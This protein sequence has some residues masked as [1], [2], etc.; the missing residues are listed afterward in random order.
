MQTAMDRVIECAYAACVGAQ[1][2]RLEPDT[3][4]EFCRVVLPRLLAELEIVKRVE[5]A[6]ADRFPG[7][8]EEAPAKPQPKKPSRRPSKARKAKARRRTR[9]S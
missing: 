4:V 2:G 5:A 1:E 9:A 8:Q 7:P 3:A 6:L